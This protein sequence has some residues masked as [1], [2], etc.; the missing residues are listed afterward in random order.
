[1]TIRYAIITYTGACDVA[2]SC[3]I[4]IHHIS[5]DDSLQGIKWSLTPLTDRVGREGKANGSVRLS[6]RPPLNLSL[7]VRHDRSSPGI[8]GQGHRLRSTV[9]VQRIWAC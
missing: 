1:L 6:V 5:A 2:Y 4:V 7:R 8:E 9:N 3:V